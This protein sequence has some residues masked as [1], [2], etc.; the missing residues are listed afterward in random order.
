MPVMRTARPFIPALVASAIVTAWLGAAA[1]QQPPPPSP[2]PQQPPPASEP[3]QL[4][5]FRT[6][7]NVVRVDV[8]VLDHRGVPVPALKPED[9]L[10]EEDGLPQKVASLKFVEANGQPTDDLSLPIRSPE[11]AAAEAAREDVRVFL[12]FWDE[13]SIDQF[14]SAI[15][16]REALMKLVGTA[17]QPTDLVALMDQ[18]TPSDAIRFT[19]NFSDLTLDVKKL[20]GRLGVFIPTRSAVE[21][22]QLAKGGDVRKLRAE[23]TMSALK[24]AVVHLGSL[25]EGRK[26]VIFVSEGIRGLGNDAIQVMSDV[27]R[28]ANESNTAIYTVDPRGLSSRG[29]SDSLHLLADNTGGRAIVNTNG[30]EVALGQVVRES[31]A[32]YLL[33][34][35]SIRNPADGR[36]HQIKVRVVRAGLDVRARHGYWA[37]SLKAM[38]EAKEAAA[39][40][41]PPD[42][43]ATALSALTPATS[44]HVLSVWTG[45]VRDASGHPAVS[46]AWG[47]RGAHNGTTDVPAKVHVS[48]SG[49]E[50]PLEFDGTVDD[51]GPTF[52]LP[53]GV[54]K[55]AVSVRDAE[56]RVID[57]EVRSV[58]VPPADSSGLSWSTPV[59]LRAR[60]PIEVRTLL[61]AADP[62]PFAGNDL[63]RADRL[64]VRAALFGTPEGATVTSRLVSRAG[65]DLVALPIA[66]VA[67]RPG[68]YQVD[69]PL[70][71]VAAGDYVIAL[72]ATR[73]AETVETFVSIRVS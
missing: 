10:I 53:E 21:D 42:A 64:L 1:Q 5:T 72:T 45:I 36:F 55:V 8:T 6:G 26:T 25:R 47:P 50:G 3:S 39:A 18:L 43:V 17:F 16:A 49:P 58:T 22:A 11:H 41:R 7:A 33:G 38:A 62:A 44:R 40:A 23:V 65:R 57:T 13:Y 14:A 30:L 15:R 32:F 73:G 46:V 34:Y 28:A 67:S 51:R 9:F 60:T 24:G 2:S 12:I 56:D 66:P 69:L 31:S 61:A 20:R 63:V 52:V 71:S 68:T 19:R 54:V 59:L 37:P 29:P 35:S 48:V 27:V 70:S 4:P